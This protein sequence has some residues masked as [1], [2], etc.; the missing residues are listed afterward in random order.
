MGTDPDS[1]NAQRSSASTGPEQQGRD[2]R[3]RSSRTVDEQIEAGLRRV[4]EDGP[5]ER[6]EMTQ[7]EGVRVLRMRKSPR[8]PLYGMP[9][10]REP[11]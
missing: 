9:P 1:D 5:S 8:R 3:R 2:Q 10:L 11:D 7:G 4:F 6:R